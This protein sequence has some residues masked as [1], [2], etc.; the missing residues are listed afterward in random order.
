LNVE[1]CGAT[2]DAMKS[3]NIEAFAGLVVAL[4]VVA[5]VIFISAWTLDYWQA[6]VFLAVFIV[7]LLAMNIYLMRSDP[8]ILEKRS[9][10]VPADKNGTGQRIVNVMGQISILFVIVLPVLDHRFGWSVVPLYLNI[11]GDLLIALGI[12]FVILEFKENTYAAPLIEVAEDQ[13]A[14][15]ADAREKHT[16][17]PKEAAE[18]LG[19][20]SGVSWK[21]PSGA[22]ALLILRHLRHD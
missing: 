9:R 18:R 7:T 5:A 4:A 11:V 6:W 1:L 19:N 10:I 21:H 3:Q 17:G 22:K 8:K 13:R 12:Y 2:V 16:S 15:S 14:I 20:P